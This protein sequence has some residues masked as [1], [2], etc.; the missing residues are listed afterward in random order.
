MKRKQEKTTANARLHNRVGSLAV[1]G[2]GCAR[3][4]TVSTLDPAGAAVRRRAIGRR[5]MAGKRGE[6]IADWS[7][8]SPPIGIICI[9]VRSLRRPW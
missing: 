5:R 8:A 7:P 9:P 2:K 4:R 3:R 6:T 1:V